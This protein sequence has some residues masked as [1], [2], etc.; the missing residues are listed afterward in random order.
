MNRH[1]LLLTS[2]NKKPYY[3]ITPSELTEKISNN[4]L[5]T[6]FYNKEIKNI[7]SFVETISYNFNSSID[8]FKKG[9]KNNNSN[10]YSMEEITEDKDI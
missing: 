8:I 4:A 10:I 6:N 7:N 2:I 3:I 1:T 9:T 5:I